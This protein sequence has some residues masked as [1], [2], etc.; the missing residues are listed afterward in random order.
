VV[1]LVA[2]GG[3]VL[4]ALRVALPVMLS[5]SLPALPAVATPD[6]GPTLSITPP[7]R[8]AVTREQMA[9]RPLLEEAARRHGLKPAYV[10]ALSYWESGWDQSRVSRTG[11]IGLMQIEPAT[12]A[13]V[14]PRLVGHPV[15]LR[16]ASQNADLGAALL[17]SLINDFDGSTRLALAAYYQGEASVRWDGLLP[18]TA[19]YADGIIA[20]AKRFEAGLPPP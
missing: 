8:P 5:P 13:D 14:A 12:A 6:P 7:V 20:L 4:L 19:R 10:L 15:D 18:E 1:T 2:I 17:R 16:D 9:V 11:A 3:G